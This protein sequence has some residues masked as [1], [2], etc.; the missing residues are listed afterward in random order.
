MQSCTGSSRTRLGLHGQDAWLPRSTRALV[1]VEMLLHLLEHDLELGQLFLR[2]FGWLG[3]P[4]V[5]R[6]VDRVIVPA[7]SEIN[8]VDSDAYLP[9]QNMS[10]AISTV[11]RA[12]AP[13]EP[14][15]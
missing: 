6:Q 5:V 15:A 4:V 14:H 7:A 3:T 9:R 12:P 13:Q 8:H 11:P 10:V 1:L 2:K